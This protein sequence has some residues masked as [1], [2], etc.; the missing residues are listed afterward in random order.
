MPPIGKV[1]Y[2]KKKKEKWGFQGGSVVNN[3]PANAG[4]MDLIPELRRSP[5]EG[6]GNPLQYSC[7]GNPI[8]RGIWQ[9][10]VRGVVKSGK[11]LSNLH[12]HFLFF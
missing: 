8:D 6:N 2:L 12:F 9:T 5:G 4:D 7:L 10:T 1:L 3:P 11:R